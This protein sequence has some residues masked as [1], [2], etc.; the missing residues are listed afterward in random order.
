MK[1]K[2]INYNGIRKWI[3]LSHSKTINSSI[4]II[5]TAINEDEEH[6]IEV[7]EQYHANI[8]ARG[9]DK[10]IDSSKIYTYGEINIDNEEDLIFIENLNLVNQDKGNKIPS[11]FDFTSGKAT[12]IEGIVK[13]ASTWDPIKWFMFAYIIIGKPK[14]IIIYEDA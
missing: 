3:I 13:E 9:G 4:P 14:R 11:T 8:E 1:E 6:Y 2:V 12:T 5:M 10:I 7:N